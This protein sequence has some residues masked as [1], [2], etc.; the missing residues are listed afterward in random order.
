M[1]DYL[2]ATAVAV[3]IRAFH[4]RAGAGPA[5]VHV[6]LVLVRVVF[7][8]CVEVAVVEVVHVPTVRHRPVAAVGSVLVA[9]A[10]VLPAGHGRAVILACRASRRQ[11]VTME[12]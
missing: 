6:E 9:V 11:V 10:I 3:P 5:A 2:V 4:G 1:R 12:T 8:R 7:V